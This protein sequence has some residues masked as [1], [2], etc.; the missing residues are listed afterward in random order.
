MNR[1]SRPR[2]LRRR[3]RAVRQQRPALAQLRS[4]MMALSF[5]LL[6]Y[7]DEKQVSRLGQVN[8]SIDVQENSGAV[9]YNS[10]GSVD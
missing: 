5:V 9:L 7:R 6:Y 8:Q 4:E 2:G 3:K 10:E 1:T